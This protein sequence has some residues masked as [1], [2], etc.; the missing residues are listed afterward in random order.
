MSKVNLSFII[1][2]LFGAGK[3]GF[4]ELRGRLDSHQIVRH[5]LLH[6]FHVPVYICFLHV[7]GEGGLGF[8][9]YHLHCSIPAG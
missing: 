4:N 2:D 9:S 6:V 3:V 5:V 1:D 8:F 7:D